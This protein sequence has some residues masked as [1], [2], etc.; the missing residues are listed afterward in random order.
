M[1]ARPD[2]CVSTPLDPG[3]R[4]I[5]PPE[6]A[7]AWQPRRFEVAG[8]WVEGVEMGEGPPLLLLPPLPGWKEAYFA[9][10]PLLAR[11]FRVITFDLRSRFERPRSPEAGSWQRA[12]WRQLVADASAIA[13]SQT[14]GPVAVF[15][16]SL[17]AALALEWAIERPNEVRALILSSGF[18]HVFTPSGSR[19]ARWLEQPAVVAGMRWLPDR[20]SAS[21]AR[22]VAARNGWVFDS[23]CDESVVELM[24]FAIRR[25]PLRLVKQRVELAFA[26]DARAELGRI[27]CPTLVLAGADDTAFARAGSDDLA[28]GIPHAARAVIEEAGH[29]HPVSRPERLAE[30]VATWLAGQKP[31]GE[32]PEAGAL[33]D[34]H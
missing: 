20:W 29:L 14:N 2:G 3:W 21:F 23:H 30:V 4:S 1:R 7:A 34:V 9:L 31:P 8:G 24:R 10:A 25:V 32:A 13:A 5:V 26:F 6:R 19:F 27:H 33:S 17:G 16:H 22:S 28:R 11:R 15:G 12:A 18:T